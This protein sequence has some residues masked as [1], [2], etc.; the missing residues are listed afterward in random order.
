MAKLVTK[1]RYYKPAEKR[2]IGGLM[3]YIAT[4]DGVEFCDE[5]KQFAPTTK[6]QRKLIE[7]ILKQFPDSVQMLEYDDYIANPT[8]KNASEFIARVLEDNAPSVMN[9]T[10]Y[11]D[12]IATRPRVEKYGSHG[13]FT[14]DDTEIILSKVSEEM[15]QHT[16]NFW[17]MIVSLRREDAERLGYN[18]AAQWKDTLRKHTAEL[19]EALKIPL[20]ELKWYAAFHN[21]SHHP[22]IHLIAY[23]KTPGIG[24]LTQ[25]G[26]HDMRSA[27][28]QD[29]FKDDLQ[30][31]YREQTERRNRLKKDWKSML[32]DIMKRIEDGTYDNPILEQKLIELSVRLSNT[33]AKKAYGY[34]QKDVKEL[35]DSIVDE[36]AKD[37]R[38]AE[39]YDLWYE[40]K[41]EIL[42]TY[43]SELPPKIPLSENKEF[44]SIKNEIVH[45]AM[46]IHSEGGDTF[47]IEPP[48]KSC[49]GGGGSSHTQHNH[50]HRMNKVSA[51]A[52]TRLF[53]SLATLFQDKIGG[54][55]EK[56][57]PVI[58][59]RQK[60]EIEEKRN[61]EISMV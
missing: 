59:R 23:S 41:Y 58:D 57:L 40:K 12:Y 25:K 61:A 44:K 46:R 55:G 7:D 27:L 36:L 19:S 54:G 26:V 60:R 35:I 3:K 38:I 29:I 14:D 13:L 1:F 49:D 22:H 16:G 20:S 47:R 42:K 30:H 39:L 37:E 4:R 17:T 15:N 32:E 2:K 45:E 28:G 33:K 51:V 24:Y 9:N 48:K 8:V 21:E 43:T 31:V 18:N 11:A 50:S 56:N 52:V 53:R 34:L 5:S 6:N 10:T